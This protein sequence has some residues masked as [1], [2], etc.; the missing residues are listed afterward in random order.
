MAE[1]SA[2]MASESGGR[3]NAWMD[4]RTIVQTTFFA[5]IELANIG[6]AAWMIIII[7]S[8]KRMTWVPHA[9]AAAGPAF[10]MYCILHREQLTFSKL[11]IQE[12]IGAVGIVSKVM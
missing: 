8:R 12:D 1:K 4:T 6:V 3:A 9:V 7:V 2:A 5:I 11:E 10:L